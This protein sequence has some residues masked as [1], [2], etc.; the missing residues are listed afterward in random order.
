MIN[1]LQIVWPAVTAV[2]MVIAMIQQEHVSVFKITLENLAVTA[3]EIIITIPIVHV[4]ISYFFQFSS[5]QIEIFR[6]FCKYYLQWSW[7]L[8]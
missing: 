3:V 5:I 4:C 7:F 6:L 2:V 8:Q 1:A